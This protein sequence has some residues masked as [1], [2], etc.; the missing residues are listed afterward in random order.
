MVI[1]KAES[2]L[3]IT[4]KGSMKKFQSLIWHSILWKNPKFFFPVQGVT[5]IP[6][7][8]NLFF[9]STHH[10][11]NHWEVKNREKWQLEAQ[12]SSPRN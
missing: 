7:R 10:T 9:S 4:P 11:S 12:V 8:I 2:I 1:H 6:L 3:I 5:S